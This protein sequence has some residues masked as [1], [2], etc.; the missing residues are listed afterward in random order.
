MKFLYKENYFCKLFLLGILAILSCILYMWKGYEIVPMPT[1]NIEQYHSDIL[2]INSIFSGFALTNL[3]ILLTISDAIIVKKLQGT[4]ILPKRNIVIAHSIIFGLVSIMISVFFVF[5][6]NVSF[7]GK[8]IQ[9]DIKDFIRRWLFSVEIGAL[10]LS[11]A[12][13]MLSIQKML[14]I[15]SRIYE[16]KRTYSDEKVSNLKKQIS[17]G[18]K[19]DD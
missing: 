2:T 15:L 3:G 9:E 7:I 4:D 6:F 18:T 5:D 8:Y 10:I 19:W 17:E 14:Q 1:E 13:F 12:Y 11:I 16:T